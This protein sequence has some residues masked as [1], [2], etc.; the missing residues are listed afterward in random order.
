MPKR[1]RKKR[2]ETVQD[3]IA[4]GKQKTLEDFW[5]NMNEENTQ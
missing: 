5:N 1:K 2:E 3:K 4:E